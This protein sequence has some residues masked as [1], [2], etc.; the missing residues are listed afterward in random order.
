LPLSLLG[1]TADATAPTVDA[2]ASRWTRGSSEAATSGCSAATT[3]GSPT[4]LSGAISAAPGGFE[5]IP[6]RT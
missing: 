2:S 3:C 5:N 6:N 4:I 1:A